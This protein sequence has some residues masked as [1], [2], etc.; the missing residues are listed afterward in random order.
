MFALKYI[1]FLFFSFEWKIKNEDDK[2]ISIHPNRGQILP[3]DSFV[4]FTIHS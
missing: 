3:N 2:E 4:S 1:G